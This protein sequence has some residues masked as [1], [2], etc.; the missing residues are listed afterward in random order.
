MGGGLTLRVARVDTNFE[1]YFLKHVSRDPLDYHF[2]IFDW[3][4]QRDRTRFFLALEGEKIEGVMLIY[5]DYVVQLRGS[6]SAVEILLDH[7]DLD[8]AELTVPKDCENIVL[9]RFKPLASGQVILMCLRKGEERIQIK[10]SPERLTIDYAEEIVKPLRDANPDWWGELTAERIRASMEENFWIGIKTNGKIVSVGNT[11]F[12]EAGSNISVV[13]THEA[14]R[15]KGYGTSIVST[16]VREILQR[17]ERA[18]IHV[19]NDNHSA[20]RV[21]TKTGFKPYKSYLLM[22]GEKI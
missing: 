11:H 4:L 5:R 12:F 3:K 16:L 2:F 6:C 8:K 21:Y 14:Y 1:E 18:L 17:S 9:E 19:L 7:L 20:I 10:H 13:A 15:N 22:R